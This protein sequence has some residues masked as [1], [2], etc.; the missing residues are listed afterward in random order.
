MSLN[1]RAFMLAQCGY[2]FIVWLVL[3]LF[4]GASMLP[5]LLSM[6][7]VWAI[8]LGCYHITPWRSI[9]GMWVLLVATTIISIGIIINVNYFTGFESANTQMP[10][11]QNPDAKRYYADALYS[12]GHEA[13]VAT[14]AKNHGYGLMISWLWRITGITIVSPL[15]LNM[16][17]MLL[18]IILSGGI[19]WRLLN[20]VMSR[21]GEWIS[22]CAMIM[23]A[24]VCYFLNSGTLLLKEAGLI[25]AFSLIGFSIISLAKL[26]TT[27]IHRIGVVVMFALGVLLISLLRFNFLIMVVVGIIMLQVWKRNN[28]L[29]GGAYLLVC[30][31][32]WL[33]VSLVMYQDGIE[34]AQI[35][36]KIIEGRGG[37]GAFFFEN[38]DH[39]TYNAIVNGYFEYPWWK[40]IMLLPMSAAVQFLI[41]LPWGYC[42]DIQFGYTL[43]YAHFSY[44]WYAVGGLLLYFVLFQMNRAPKLLC[45]MVMWGVLMWLV[46]AYLFAGTVSR[47][48]LPFLPLLIPAVVYVVGSCRKCKNLKMWMYSYFVLLVIGLMSGYVVQKGLLS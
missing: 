47:Y 4:P 28:L 40:K 27:T 42:D 15:I 1:N 19:A 30:I 6:I 35:A 45:R 36:S 10:L 26:S 24:S 31:V 22:T 11:L 44:P 20:G 12:M 46:P 8:V 37:I 16:L 17:F 9:S 48:T 23:S 7:G 32:G 18:A 5:T 43:A 29:L 39:D 13:G 41:P 2:I 34:T 21:S 14:E 33:M 3:S 25:F 38:T